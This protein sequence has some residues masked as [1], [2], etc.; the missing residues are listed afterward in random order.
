MRSIHV[1]IWTDGSSLGNPG[2]SG[3]AARFEAIHADADGNGRTEDQISN[4]ITHATNNQ[5]ELYAVYKALKHLTRPCKVT[6]HTDS[7]YVITIL[8]GGN[9]KANRKLVELTRDEADKHDIE[10]VKIDR[11]DN[12]VD[13]AARAEARKLETRQAA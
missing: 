10:F 3:Y 12:P 5:A 11:D 9:A 2:P 13:N 8:E 7:Q 4:A 6:L 1:N